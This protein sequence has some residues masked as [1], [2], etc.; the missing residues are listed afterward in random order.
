MCVHADESTESRLAQSVRM[1]RRR[2]NVA[3]FRPTRA[4][5]SELISEAGGGICLPKDLVRNTAG[6]VERRRP[7]RQ[8]CAR[9]APRLPSRFQCR[10]MRIISEPLKR[11]PR[12]GPKP[13]VAPVLLVL[14]VGPSVKPVALAVWRFRVRGRVELEEIDPG[15]V[16]PS[17]VSGRTREGS[18][19][20]TNPRR[21]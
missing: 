15:A 5:V 6:P 2:S 20:R 3:R 16:F 12:V 17:R 18:A 9:S 10:P 13:G 1:C 8:A 11:E 7:Q 14:V 4:L 21:R 19:P